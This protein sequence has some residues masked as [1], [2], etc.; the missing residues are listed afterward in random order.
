[1]FPLFRPVLSSLTQYWPQSLPCNSHWDLPV[2]PQSTPPRPTLIYPPAAPPCSGSPPG[3][4][5]PLIWSDTTTYPR[6][7]SSLGRL[8]R[9]RVPAVRSPLSPCSYGSLAIEQSHLGAPLQCLH[10]PQWSRSQPAPLRRVLFLGGTREDE[11]L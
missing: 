3:P 5:L 11:A 2:Y 7:R 10:N 1:M 9:P 8:R 4:C 6:Q